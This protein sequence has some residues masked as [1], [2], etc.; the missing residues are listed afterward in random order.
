M[1]WF[2]NAFGGGQQAA[3]QAQQQP[4]QSSATRGPGNQQAAGAPP[5][6][7]ATSGGQQLN[8]GQGQQQDQQ[9]PQST[10]QPNHPLD[11]FSGLWDNTNQQQPEAPPSFN[12]NPEDIKKV[13]SNLKFTEGISPD[14]FQQAMSG[15]QQAFFEMMDHV[16]RQAYSMALQHNG[17]LTDKFV[18]SRAEFEK[19]SMPS[20]IKKELVSSNLQSTVNTKHPVIK[21]ELTRIAEAMHSQ[22][23][24]ASPAEIAQAATEYFSQL[25][26]AMGNKSDPQ[27]ETNKAKEVDWDSFFS[28]QGQGQ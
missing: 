24:D 10:G 19:K 12:L 6:A 28:G 7:P 14:K 21:K 13:S 22:Y 9:N 27:E 4:Q 16:G 23:P 8:P 18:S 2:A 25:S 20:Q 5:R 11:H 15:D 17:V 3:Q 1:N 26:Q